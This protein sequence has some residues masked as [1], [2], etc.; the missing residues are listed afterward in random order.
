MN[1][2]R[3]GQL[4]Y[5]LIVKQINLFMPDGIKEVYLNGVEQCKN[6]GKIVSRSIWGNSIIIVD[7][8]V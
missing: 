2:V 1:M 6:I 3:K 4:N 8:L 7:S 5:N